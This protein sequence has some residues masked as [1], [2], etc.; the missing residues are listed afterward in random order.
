MVGDEHVGRQR[1]VC[2]GTLL[3]A[4]EPAFDGL[5][6]VGVSVHGDDRI[7]HDVH[8]DRTLIFEGDVVGEGVSV[9]LL[10]LLLLGELF[11]LF[12]S[13]LKFL[14]LLLQ[15]LLLLPDLVFLLLEL[16]RLS[17]LLLPRTLRRTDSLL[18]L[19]CFPAPR[20]YSQLLLQQCLPLLLQPFF[21]LLLRLP[22]LL[23]EFSLQ[24]LCQLPVFLF[25]RQVRVLVA[26][27]PRNFLFPVLLL[28][29]L[30]RF[31]E[32]PD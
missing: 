20:L 17:P 13:L 25:L 27:L 19:L 31:W 21:F 29:P 32:L 6:L 10:L 18:L 28:S 30:V 12:N 9:S 26:I 14:F 23:F 11:K 16:Q 22:L 8:R 2:L 24:P 7:S 3:M 5:S 4:L 15:Q 1:E